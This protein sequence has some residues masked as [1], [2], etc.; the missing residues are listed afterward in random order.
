MARKARKS[1]ALKTTRKFGKTTYRKKGGTHRLK[2][3]A[4]K[5]AAASRNRGKKARITRTKRGYT[6][7][8]RG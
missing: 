5:S 7:Y 6:V 1:V 3:A 4:K 2:R 8:T